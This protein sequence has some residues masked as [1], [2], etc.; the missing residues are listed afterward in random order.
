HSTVALCCLSFAES[1]FFPVPPDV[2]LMPMA[3]ERRQRAWWYAAVC[4]ASSVVGGMFGYLIGWGLWEIVSDFC[5]RFLFSQEQFS[6]VTGLYQKWD[7]WIVF[8]AGFTPLPYKVFTIAG[9][10]SHISLP[11]LVIAS[12]VGRGGRFFLV[13]GLMWKF[14]DPVRKFIDRYFNWLCVLFGILLVGG[15]AALKLLH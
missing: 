14:G 11:M 7:F 9:G 4:T 1:S 8:L 6:T 2:L 5:F 13:A 10:V 15:V 12:I 3:M